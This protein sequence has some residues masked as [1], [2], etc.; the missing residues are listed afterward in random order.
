M[1]AAASFSPGWRK[2]DL[3]L[4]SAEVAKHEYE[5]LVRTWWQLLLFVGMI[6]IFILG[7]EMVDFSW[8]FLSTIGKNWINFI[9]YLNCSSSNFHNFILS[10]LDC[11]GRTFFNLTSM[12]SST[13]ASIFH[14]LFLPFHCC[15]IRSKIAVWCLSLSSSWQLETKQFLHSIVLETSW[16]LVHLF[17]G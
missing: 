15:S 4:W 8:K 11:P 7:Y 13:C 6:I 10:N 5:Q 17:L 14:Y 9:L 16:M 3:E 1:L 2:H 12:H